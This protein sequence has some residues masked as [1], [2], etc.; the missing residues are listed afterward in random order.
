MRTLAF[1]STLVLL[2]ACNE[3]Q[4]TT[5]PSSRSSNRAPT[6]IGDARSSTQL[7]SA[8]GKPTD[9]VGFTH[10]TPVITSTT[11]APGQTGIAHVDCPA[12][13]TITGG[14][15]VVDVSA[16]VLASTLPAIMASIADGL[17][18]SVVVVNNQSGAVS[19][20]V[21]VQALCAS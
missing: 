8:Q 21:R 3:D 5:A 13:T 14:G 20:T 12:G 4:H 18:W 2:A 7:A 1:L 15:Y 9:A 16:G 17:G 11:F 6:Q 10:I 19:Q